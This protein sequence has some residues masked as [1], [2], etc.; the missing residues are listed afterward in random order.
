MCAN[1]VSLCLYGV[2]FKFFFADKK[3]KDC[4]EGFFSPFLEEASPEHVFLVEEEKIHL[5]GKPISEPFPDASLL[6]DALI[7]HMHGLLF[8]AV[9]EFLVIHAGA[10]KKDGR[11]FLFPGFSGSGKSTI[12]AWFALNGWE[13]LGDDLVFVGFKDKKIYPYPTPLRLK[14]PPHKLRLA[15]EN[16]SGLKIAQKFPCQGKPFYYLQPERVL[17][18]CFDLAKLETFIFPVFLPKAPLSLKPFT[19]GDVFKALLSHAI[20]FSSYP[21]EAFDL[22]F[23]LSKKT[24][25]REFTFSKLSHLDAIL[26]EGRP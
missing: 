15:L 24:P 16:Q 18:T 11:L 22:V 1:E 13:Y 19:A 7:S 8:E 14:D 20:N 10:V 6:L 17:K 2:G 4:F 26:P 9:K 5:N 25:G 23:E 3:T 21:Q 12:V